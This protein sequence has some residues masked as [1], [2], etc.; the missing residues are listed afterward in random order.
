MDFQTLQSLLTTAPLDVIAVQK[1]CERIEQDPILSPKCICQSDVYIA[2]LLTYLIQNELDYARFVWKRIPFNVKAACP[3]LVAT[4]QVGSQLWSGYHTGVFHA[5]EN[6]RTVLQPIHQGLL[7]SLIDNYQHRVF[8]L[9][10]KAYVCISISDAVNLMGCT[11]DRLL[12]VAFAANWTL[13]GNTAM[14]RPI[15]P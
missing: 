10:S 7:S 11:H 12:E 8:D 13:D 4:W 1:E 3:P 6:L 2:L 14:I 9:I 5:I 15:E